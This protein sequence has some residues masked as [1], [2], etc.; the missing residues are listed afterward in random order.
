MLLPLI[1]IGKQEF[2]WDGHSDEASLI[3]DSKRDWFVYSAQLPTIVGIGEEESRQDGRDNEASQVE[4]YFIQH[5][6]LP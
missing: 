2:R 1:G 3:D 6:F 4:D 5:W